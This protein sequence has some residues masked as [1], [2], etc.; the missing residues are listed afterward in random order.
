MIYQNLANQSW[1]K[2][3]TGQSNLEQNDRRRRRPAAS[4]AAQRDAPCVQATRLVFEKLEKFMLCL[5]M[6]LTE[7][8]IG[9]ITK[10]NPKPTLQ[11][12]SGT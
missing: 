1:N 8:K 12:V 2:G 4:D 11:C 3:P 5:S 6:W 9:L 7:R 10:F